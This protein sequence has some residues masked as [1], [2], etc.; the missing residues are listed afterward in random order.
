MTLELAEALFVS[1]RLA[2]ENLPGLAVSLLE[3]GIDCPALRELA[4]LTR[5]TLRDAGPVFERMVRELGRALPTRDESA[6]RL[7]KALAF[8]VMNGDIS[9]REAAQRGVSLAISFDYGDRFMPFYR[10]DDDY[11]LPF[12][13]GEEIDAWLKEHCECLLRGE[14]S[15]TRRLTR[16]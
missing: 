3:S 8:A 16:P 14:K 13:K 7:A 4:G 5:P 10:A 9:F 2:G 11:D 6:W 12:H 1:D 15:A